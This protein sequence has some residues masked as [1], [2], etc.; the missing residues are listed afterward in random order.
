MAAWNF[1]GSTQVSSG[2]IWNPEAASGG[3][4]S[5]FLFGGTSAPAASD[6]RLPSSTPNGALCN[7]NGA[8]YPFTTWAVSA[9]NADGSI[10][11]GAGATSGGNTV[12]ARSTDFAVNFT[13]RNVDVGFAFNVL[14]IVFSGN[15]VLTTAAAF[16]VRTPIWVSSDGLTWTNITN[17]AGVTA[18]STITKLFAGSNGEICLITSDNKMCVSTNGG[19]TWT[20]AVAAP[21]TGVLKGAYTSTYGWLLIGATQVAKTLT[22]SS[23]SYTLTSPF[24]SG[25]AVDIESDGVSRYLVAH[26]DT[27][28]RAPGPGVQICDD[29]TNWRFV[30]FSADIGTDYQP[31]QVRFNG[32]QW[33]VLG[34]PTVA[35]NGYAVWLTPQMR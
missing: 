34:A 11:I 32:Y 4:G 14:Q 13:S 19:T 3:L 28:S 23:P 2:I 6:G 24:G 20:A 21:I 17:P 35:S 16:N 33:A 10:F 27:A 5:W 31:K 18:A 22:L 25:K 1:F 9:V 26:T 7:V 29:G 8:A 12:I 15:F 30:R